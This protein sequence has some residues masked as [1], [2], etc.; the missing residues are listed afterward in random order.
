M[1]TLPPPRRLAAA[2]L[3]GALVLAGCSQGSA[4][5]PDAAQQ[6]AQAR[7]AEAA[8]NLDT[9]RQ[10]LRIHNDQMA[11]SMGKDIVQRFPDSA[12]AKE[13]QQTLPV[14]EKRWTENSEKARLAALW[15]YQVAPM[16]G[17]TQ[18]TAATYDSQPAGVRVRLRSEG[19]RSRRTRRPPA[20]RR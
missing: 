17:G 6:Q 1:M 19:A 11:V 7:D 13:V 20:N 15:Q 16:A 18:S 2:A 14:I 4:P 10:L 3:A 12:A 9:Y 8:R 5:A